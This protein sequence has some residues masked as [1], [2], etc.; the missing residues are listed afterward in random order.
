[1]WPGPRADALSA[2]GS[3]GLIGAFP[4]GSRSRFDRGFARRLK[5]DVGL[6]W[7]LLANPKS[8]RGAESSRQ[9]RK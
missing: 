4:W 7:H 5:L 8:I 9:V 3:S 1:M 2:M 6:V